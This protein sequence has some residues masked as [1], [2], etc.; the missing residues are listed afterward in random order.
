MERHGLQ[1]LLTFVMTRLKWSQHKG[2]TLCVTPKK[3]NDQL[4]TKLTT[5]KYE[6]K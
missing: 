4:K 1:R 2:D 6:I 3:E 5:L